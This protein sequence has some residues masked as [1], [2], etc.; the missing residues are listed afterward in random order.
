M[1]EQGR[2]LLIFEVHYIAEKRIQK[3]K[4]EQKIK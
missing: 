3:Q 2:K 1:D 4:E